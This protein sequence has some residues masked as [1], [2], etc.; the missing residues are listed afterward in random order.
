[1]LFWLT[2]S[3]MGISNTLATITLPQPVNAMIVGFQKIFHSKKICMFS[4]KKVFLQMFYPNNEW[5]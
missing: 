5:E 4:G 3:E 1:M 2:K